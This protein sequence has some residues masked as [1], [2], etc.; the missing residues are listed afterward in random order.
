MKNFKRSSIFVILFLLVCMAF[1]TVA[2]ASAGAEEATESVASGKLDKDMSGADMSFGER[3]EYA[4]QGTVTGMVM[5]FAVLGLLFG[6]I[7]LSKVVFY[8]V[9]ERKKKKK[10]KTHASPTAVDPAPV[11]A[12]EKNQSED[13]GQLIAVI[14]AAVAAMIESGDYKDEFAGGF[15][16]V[17]FKRSAKGAWNK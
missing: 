9:P 15:R 7:S 14:T 2:F 1:T 5:V 13:D 12:A 8:D 4:L 16:V 11:A 6:I 17:S 10:Q 3:A